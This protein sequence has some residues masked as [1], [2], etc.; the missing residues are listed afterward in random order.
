MHSQPEW[1]CPQ[2]G[3]N[4][5]FVCEMKK[6][7]LA[8]EWFV[9]FQSLTVSD[10][11]LFFRI[12]LLSLGF[13]RYS[14]SNID[15]EYIELYKVYARSVLQNT[16]KNNGCDWR[17]SNHCSFLKSYLEKWPMWAYWLPLKAFIYCPL[18][19][20]IWLGLWELNKNSIYLILQKLFSMSFFNLNLFILI[21]G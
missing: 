6:K 3:R 14:M 10:K 7:I 18:C 15:I 13:L 21:G 8:L 2:K 17:A 11:I 1:Y 12:Q 16:S 20:W 9:A 19:P 4:W 5:L